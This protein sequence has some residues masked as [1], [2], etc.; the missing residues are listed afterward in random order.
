MA[1][2]LTALSKGHD[3]K[4]FDCGVPELNGW[5]RTTAMQHQKNGM[6]KTFV[7]TDEGNTK[8]ILGF[9]AMTIRALT[10]SSALS[11][12]MRKKLPHQVPGFTLARLAVS[13][14]AQRCGI[15]EFLLLDAMERVFMAAQNV[16]GFALFVDAKDG[17]ASFYAKYG[18]EPL[19]DDPDTLVMPIAS[20]PKF[21][22]A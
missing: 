12:E 22:P 7:Y 3:V 11:P 15:G 13:M 21:M 16:G 9:V 20:M 5:L 8:K 4:S 18:F 10:P 17:A 2:K 1:R 14:D 19:P 6:S